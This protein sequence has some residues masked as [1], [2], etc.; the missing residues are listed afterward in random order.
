[1]NVVNY[2]SIYLGEFH[3]EGL[4]SGCGAKRAEVGGKLYP[5]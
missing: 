5:K 3:G 2:N 1:M 4:S